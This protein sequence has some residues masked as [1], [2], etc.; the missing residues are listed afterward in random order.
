MLRA[1]WGPD[2]QKATS[3]ISVTAR[4]RRGVDESSIAYLRPFLYLARSLISCH[5]VP[6][7]AFAQ[8]DSFSPR[9]RFS[10]AVC[11][12]L[13][14]SPHGW[15]NQVIFRKGG[16]ESTWHCVEQVLNKH[17]CKLERATGENSYIYE[18][19]MLLLSCYSS[20]KG[21]K[22][23]MEADQKHVRYNGTEKTGQ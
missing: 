20:R 17:A 22:A 8:H 1:G 14:R 3:R 16:S 10:F 6:C 18:S 19:D 5:L 21:V 11:A 13:V 12:S 7:R 9:T 2:T 15:R 23:K 4:K